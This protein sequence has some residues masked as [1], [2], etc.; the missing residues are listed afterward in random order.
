MTLKISPNNADSRIIRVTRPFQ[1]VS[2]NSVKLDRVISASSSTLESV[3]DRIVTRSVL[4]EVVGDYQLRPDTL[5]G[6]GALSV[7]YQSL[8]EDIATVDA[9]GLA[10]HLSDGAATIIV[11]VG[12]QSRNLTIEFES[13]TG[14]TQDVFFSYAEGTLGR[15]V[16]ETIDGL[17][18]DKSAAQSLNIFTTQNHAEQNYLRNPEVWAHTIPNCLTCLSPWNSTGGQKRAGTLISPRHILFAAHYQIGTGA[19]VRFVQMDGTVVNRTMT[20]KKTHPDYEPYYP[21]ITIGLLDEDVPAGI[22]FARVLPDEWEDYLP[23]QNTEND[24]RL[25][26]LTLDQEEKALVTDLYRE[27]HNTTFMAPTDNKRLEFYETKVGG[28]SG[29]P[30]ILPVNGLPVLLTVWT[31]GGAGRGTSVREHKVAINQIMTDLGGGYQLT[32]IDLT[33]FTNFGA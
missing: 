12:G 8:N 11:S 30:A 19:T 18:V 17:L 31:Y 26:C 9:D 25:P 1:F 27:T 14:E 15:H 20:S 2:V 32:E 16:A 23:S 21:D 7:I 28:D 29:N 6:A 33:G 5:G 10:T 13:L 24:G 22:S 4:S 3:K